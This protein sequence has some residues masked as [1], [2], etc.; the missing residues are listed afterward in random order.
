MHWALTHKCISSS[1]YSW[2]ATARNRQAPSSPI[3]LILY[4]FLLITFSN[5]MSF[6]SHSSSVRVCPTW[7]YSSSLLYPSSAKSSPTLSGT[8]EGTREQEGKG[9]GWSD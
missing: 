3:R 1:P 2:S 9:G 8:G 6:S 4:P 7:L 5:L